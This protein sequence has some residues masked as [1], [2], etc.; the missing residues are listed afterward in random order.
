MSALIRQ[1]M[2]QILIFGYLLGVAYWAW[3]YTTGLVGTSH[4]YLWSFLFEVVLLVIGGI[5]GILISKKWG[6]L[7]SA[8]GRAIFFF[9]AGIIVW[10]LGVLVFLY[11]NVFLSIEAPYPS[12][13]DLFFILSIPFL[14]VG[15]INLGKGIGG[16]Y[17]LRA[18]RGKAIFAMIPL[19][20]IAMSYYNL[21]WV[22]GGVVFDFTDAGIVQ[23][24]L[25]ILYSIQDAL[26][27]TTIFLI[28][29]LSY[30]VFGGRFK[31]SINLLFVGFLGYY[32]ADL[33]YSITIESGAYYVADWADLLYLSALSLICVGIVALDI[34][35]ISSRVKAELIMFAP[36]TSVAIN[37]LT[38]GI[39]Q[40]QAQ[41]IGPIAWDE[42]MKVPGLTADIKNNNLS[43]EGDPK[44]VLEK[45]V[46]KYEELFGN[47]SL[48][49]CKDVARKFISQLPSEQVPEVLK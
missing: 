48:Q 12:I 45:L 21:V 15:L 26:L 9:S 23:I 25:D 24:I 3:I 19:F 7:S 29:G 37:G 32:I 40:R 16:S 34:K 22:K 1:R 42:A 27:I 4:N 2:V 43:I 18:L 49:I 14:I 46:G 6:F 35:G 41:I 36:R 8:L 5:Y 38:L 13:A 10:S 17:K 30:R 44:D 33:L 39:I 47:A 20:T 11:Y 28:Y 31:Q